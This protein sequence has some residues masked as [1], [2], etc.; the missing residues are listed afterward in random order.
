MIVASFVTCE[1]LE[2]LAVTVEV[3]FWFG[4]TFL[5]WGA[6]AVIDGDLTDLNGSSEMER[7]LN[8]SIRCNMG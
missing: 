1:G 6:R 8:R 2:G 7:D 5:L 4:I 3:G